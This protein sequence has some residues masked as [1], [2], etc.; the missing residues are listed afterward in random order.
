MKPSVSIG[1]ETETQNRIPPPPATYTTFLNAAINIRRFVL[2]HL[3]L[4]RMRPKRVLPRSN[5]TSDRL[6][7]LKY[8]MHP[9]Y[10]EPTWKS[11][12][13]LSAWMNWF[14]GGE[15]PGD[16]K[17]FPQGFLSSEVGPNVLIGKGHD[18]MEETRERLMQANRG[19]CPFVT[20]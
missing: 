14:R 6:F 15:L 9:W 16:S 17:Y 4:P 1:G 11:R 3:S 13:G 5:P 12:W 19:G 18:Q 8:Q 10:I 2:R 7:L 20:F